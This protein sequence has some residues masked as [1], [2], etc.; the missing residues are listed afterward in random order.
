MNLAMVALFASFF[1]NA[2]TPV[3]QPR[4]QGQY[5]VCD[6]ASGVLSDVDQVDWGSGWRL[7]AGDEQNYWN[8][9]FLVGPYN[10]TAGLYASSTALPNSKTLYYGTKQFGILCG[11]GSNYDPNHHDYLQFGGT[12]FESGSDLKFHV[13]GTTD[14]KNTSSG[15]FEYSVVSNRGKFSCYQANETY[16]QMANFQVQN[17]RYQDAIAS[18]TKSI[19]YQGRPYQYPDYYAN[20]DFVRRSVS[21]AFGSGRDHKLNN[22]EIKLAEG[23][24]SEYDVTGAPVNN[25]F[26]VDCNDWGNVG[27]LLDGTFYA[28]CSLRGNFTVPLDRATLAKYVSGEIPLNP[29]DQI[30][31]DSP[32]GRLIKRSVALSLVV[33]F[34][35]EKNIEVSSLSETRFWTGNTDKY[36]DGDFVADAATSSICEVRLKKTLVHPGFPTSLTLGFSAPC[37]KSVEFTCSGNPCFSRV[38]G[39]SL[40]LL[41]IDADHWQVGST[42]WGSSGGLPLGN[43]HRSFPRVSAGK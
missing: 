29:V 27:Y 32:G 41:F 2:A 21:E 7:V 12:I 3:D 8:G 24:A 5:L 14:R 42:S 43:Y 37:N 40:T 10:A 23:I 16:H 39:L 9:V 31:M 35:P 4:G 38:E 26:S 6:V 20:S 22:I 28:R 25:N 17:C 30:Q 34:A 36:D 33:K 13:S 18:N 19:V 15:S 1:V 11:T